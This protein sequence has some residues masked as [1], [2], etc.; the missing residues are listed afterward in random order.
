MIAECRSLDDDIAVATCAYRKLAQAGGHRYRLARKPELYR[1]IL[2]AEHRSEQQVAWMPRDQ[3]ASGT[4][5][6]TSPCPV[7]ASKSAP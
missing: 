3:D 7:R 4:Q 2:G 6:S 1:H 5:I